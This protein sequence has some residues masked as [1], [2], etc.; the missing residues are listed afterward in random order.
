[1]PV[2]IERTT[3]DWFGAVRSA[4]DEA[5]KEAGAETRPDEC[6]VKLKILL[7]R[8]LCA[9]LAARIAETD[10]LGE[11]R[12]EQMRRD[13]FSGLVEDAL[14]GIWAEDKSLE[15]AVF[16]DE[17]LRE[18]RDKTDFAG[19]LCR[20]LETDVSEE[21]ARSV[22]ERAEQAMERFCEQ[23]KARSA[24]QERN[25]DD[26]EPPPGMDEFEYIDWIMTH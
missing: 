17:C 3:R 24:P 1:M 20:A 4:A 15:I 18:L 13:V 8:Y 19:M 22:R 21:T 6:R 7:I 12:A 16:L 26:D 11:E 10:G 14:A 25:D 2:D 9:P 23:R 5:A